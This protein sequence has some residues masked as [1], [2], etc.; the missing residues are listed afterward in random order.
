[1]E[2]L[3]VAAGARPAAVAGAIAGAVREE[4]KTQIQVIGAG[5]L[6]QATKAVII[7]RGYVASGGLDL[8]CIP[9]FVDLQLGQEERTAI[10]IIVEPR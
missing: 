9:S 5:A 10:K 2:T 7:A 4:G 3:K 6:N 1:M 8:V